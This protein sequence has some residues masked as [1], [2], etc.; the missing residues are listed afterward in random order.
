LKLSDSNTKFFHQA[1]KAKNRIEK[2]LDGNV[3]SNPHEVVNFYKRL[4]GTASHRLLGVDITVL[5]AGAQL[6]ADD[7][8][9][10]CRTVRYE[11]IDQALGAI[12]DDKAPG[13]DGFNAFFYK[14]VWHIHH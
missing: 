11:E 2:L 8:R 1:V 9:S 6:S 13:V 5:R 14:K 12:Q 7:A 4:Q 3:V 10:L